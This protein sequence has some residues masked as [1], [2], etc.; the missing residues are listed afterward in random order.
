MSH[1][2]VGVA[3]SSSEDHCLK[4]ML[5]GGRGPKQ[6]FK[7]RE[8]GKSVK[9]AVF[10]LSCG[11]IVA[12]GK[13]RNEGTENFSIPNLDGSGMRSGE[14]V[15]WSGSVL[16]K[17]DRGGTR[18]R[19]STRHSADICSKDLRKEAARKV[20]KKASRELKSAGGWGRILD[21]GVPYSGITH[22]SGGGGQRL[23][24]GMEGRAR[25]EE[26][27]APKGQVGFRQEEIEI[28]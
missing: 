12:G 24:G 10:L 11:C 16:L 28:R 23:V 8:R 22:A 25:Y 13:K 15:P 1:F 4:V 3:S 19:T 21:K 17:G 27:N 6:S 7:H 5:G 26:R 9:I 18:K 2:T 20:G 14:E